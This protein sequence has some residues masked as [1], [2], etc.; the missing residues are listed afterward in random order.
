MAECRE[1]SRIK[2][3]GLSVE[4]LE[5]T[6]QILVEDLENIGDE[7]LASYFKQVGG[8]VEGVVVNEVHQSAIVTFKEKK[9][10]IL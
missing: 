8:E 10:M 5:V 4:L 6:R 7:L 3:I 2:K 9:G 1:N